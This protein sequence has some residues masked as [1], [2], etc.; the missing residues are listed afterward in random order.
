MDFQL[1]K[2]R[3]VRRLL[4]RSRSTLYS[5]MARGLFPK[6]I[7]AGRGSFWRNDEIRDL[8]AAYGA[9]ADEDG[10]RSLCVSFY[11]RRRGE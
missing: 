2:L 10:L 11:R 1:L 5:E 3:E 9:G 6:P 4:P 7:K 8:I